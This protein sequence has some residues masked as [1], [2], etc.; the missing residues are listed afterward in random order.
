[1]RKVLSLILLAVSLCLTGYSQT[2]NQPVIDGPLGTVF[3]FLRTGSNWIVAPY[4]I[5]DTGS[6]RGGAGLAGLVKVSDHFLTG[7]RLDYLNGHDTKLWMPSFSAQLQY[8]IPLGKAKFIPLATSS[9]ATPLTGRQDENAQVTGIFG[10]GA[11]LSFNKNLGLF[12]EVEKWTGF[13]GNQYRGG[14]YWKF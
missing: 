10:V 6:K 4:A 5:Y 11:A 3:D 13:S 8:P 12:G 14:F 7:L 9:I 1:M 2:N